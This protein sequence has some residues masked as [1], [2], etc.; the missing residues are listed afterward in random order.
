M[1]LQVTSASSPVSDCVVLALDPETGDPAGLDAHLG[2]GEGCSVRSLLVEGNDVYLGGGYRGGMSATS[3]PPALGR[4]DGFVAK[5]DAQSGEVHWV[6]QLGGDS[7]HG[8]GDFVNAMALGPGGSLF[9]CGRTANVD[10]M[11]TNIDAMVAELDTGDGTL[12]QPIAIFGGARG[13]ECDAIVLGP[14]NHPIVTARFADLTD[15]SGM[16]FDPVDD[17][18][19][20]LVMAL[21]P[22][23]WDVL[24]VKRIAGDATIAGPGIP[25]N[26][27]AH[28]L[29]ID[30]LGN[31][32]V[33][34][35]INGN[36]GVPGHD[37]TD[38][39]YAPFVWSFT[40]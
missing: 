15:L 36:G 3:L 27:E 26:D 4:N 31:V 18:G 7:E 10:A 30:P 17:A 24:W 9:L 38:A 19:D 35:W 34:G 28:G 14:Q 32:V 23:G 40:P 11:V 21:D 8:F 33:A 6:K 16:S 22:Q 13:D 25:G 20:S 1:G 5:L 12:R 2:T 39:N 37:L 29:A